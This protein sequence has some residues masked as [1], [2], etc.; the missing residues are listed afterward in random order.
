VAFKPKILVVEGDAALLKQLEATIKLMGGEPLCLTSVREAAIIA[1][2]QKFD[3]AFVDWD[4][5]ELGGG[6]QLVKMLRRS[7]SNSTIPIAMLTANPSTKAIGVGFKL[8]VTFYLTKPFGA[9]E[10]SRLLNVS[11]G[12]MLEERRRYAR[13]PIKMAVVCKWGGKTHSGHSLDISASGLLL[14]ILPPPEAGAKIG[15]EFD[16]PRSKRLC[17]VDA[18]VARVDPNHQVALRFLNLTPEQRADIMHYT[19]RAAALAEGSE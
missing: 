19:S 9:A 8:G 3:G 18:R 15:V 1:N 5:K 4:T 14:T 11:R 6:E 7:K 17:E 2:K 16:L 12:A 13:V 10:L